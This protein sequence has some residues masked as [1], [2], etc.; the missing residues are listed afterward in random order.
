MAV[1]HFSVSVVARGS[2]R[3]AVLSAAYR[4]CAKMEFEREARTIDYTRK[5]GLLH[6]E[7]VIP[8]DAPEWVRSMIAARSVAGASEAF[9]N[10]VEG[11]ERRSDAQLAKDV[12]I[13]LPLELTAEQNIALMRDFL[14]GHITSKGM[15]ADWVYHDAPGNPHVHLMTTLRPL[16]EDGFGSKKV[17]VLGPGG[18]PIRNDA[19]KIVYDLWAGST[20]DFNAF[21]DGWFAC[22]N[23]HL[24]LAG[25]D[26]RIDGRSF[27]KQGIDLEPTIHLGVGTKAIE[28]KSAGATEVVSLERLAQQEQRRSENARRI[29][30]FPEIVLDLIMREKSVFDERDVAKILH[31]YIDDAGLFERLMLGILQSPRTLRTERE[32]I[33]FTTGL[34]APAKYTTREMIRLEAEMANRA[35]WL[36]QRSSHGVRAAVLSATFSRHHRLSDEQQAAIEHVAGAERIA[37]VVG[38]AGAGKTTMMKAAREAWEA[39]GYRVVG[40]ALAGKAAEGLEKEAGIAS[41]TLSSWELRWNEG[42]NQLDAKT[43][44]VLDEAG[45]VSSRQMALLVEVATKAGAKLV[46]V[47]DPEQLQP[48]EAGAA[49]R[50]IADRIGYAELETIYRQREQWMRDASLDLA[51]GKVGNAVGAY[52]A[53]GRVIGSDLKADA[54]DNLIAAWDRD[55]DPAKTSLILAHLR[56]DVRMLN[57]MARIKLLERG[58][59]GDGAMFKTADGDRNFAAGDQIVFLKNESSLGVKNGML[60]KVVE[61]AP[62]RIVAEIGEGEHRRQVTVEQR[63]YNNLDLGYAT[64]IHK[65]QGATVDRVKVLASLSLDRHL[66]YVAMTRHREDLGVY[67]GRRSFTKAG[68]LIPILSR[69]NAKETTL[70]YAGGPFYRQALRFAEA[71]GLDLVKVARTLVRDQL[72]WTVRQKQK[73]ADLGARLA[74]IGAALGL[75][76]GSNKQSIPNT[77]KEAKPM[78]SGITTFPKSLE[79]AVEDKLAADPGLKKQWE[80]VSTRFHL[81]YAQPDGAFKAINVDAMLKDR[82]VAQSTLA[83]IGGEPESF[84]ALKGKTGLLAS[85]ADKQDREKAIANVPA[86]TRNLERY[87]RERAE[88]ER[89]H[90]SEERA[91]RYRVSVDI[92]ALSP[93]AKQTLERVRDAIDRNDLPAGLEYALADKMVKAELEGFA[94]AVSERFGERTFLPLAAKD[95]DGKTFDTVTAGMTSGQKAEVR[96]A[97]NSMRTVQQ[98]A[99]HERTTEALKQAETMRQ[100]KSQGLSLK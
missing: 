3:S 37:A 86:L 30:R 82:T 64:T 59:L 18:K 72:G 26:I 54:V 78:V 32:R 99:A 69:K 56:R 58:I 13:A 98:L 16:T 43:V 57:Q 83:R 53:N 87:L 71:R 45:M 1:P 42:R 61:A 17:A 31:R 2:G 75:V 25:L 40:A 33:D 12:I 4:H 5:Q 38:R 23:K 85:H 80:D 84:G 62:G 28:R 88:A 34:R 10:K 35:V 24:A 100:T 77:I 9:W 20:E 47:G 14:A 41:R 65:S 74:A 60:A 94:K 66:T 36:S 52:R 29:E 19:G 46:L 73:L 81:V 51:R 93:S 95:T 21:R 79:Q 70:D 63:F 49:F 97:W 48:I 96:S 39:A 7:F 90:E 89:K 27:E 68:G 6:E 22:Q 91:V 50:A 92:P 76:R 67:Y 44:L 11:C 8:A 55:Y 15:V